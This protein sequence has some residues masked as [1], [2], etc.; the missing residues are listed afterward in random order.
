MGPIEENIVKQAKKRNHP[1][2]D[3]IKNKP[4][5]PFGMQFYITSFFDISGERQTGHALGY[6]SWK[7]IV[8]YCEYYGLDYDETEEFLYYIRK[9]D[10]EYV[11]FMNKKYGPK[12][13]SK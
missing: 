13:I 8:G 10:S 1:I 12:H 7:S 9:M 6:L 2:P 11:P 5:V 4:I 3:R